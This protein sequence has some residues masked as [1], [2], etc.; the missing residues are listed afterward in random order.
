LKAEEIAARTVTLKLKT[1]AFRLRTRAATLAA[2]TVL[3]ESI[4]A[5]GSR[6]LEREA[7]GTR[8]RLIG[9][10]VKNYAPTADAD[11]ADL[12]DPDGARRKRVE[13]AMDAL[14]TRFGRKAIVKGRS[15]GTAS[16]PGGKR[17]TKEQP[18]RP[19]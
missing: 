11:P 8:Y 6:L 3:A 16:S 2:P 15:L 1:S 4:Y 18:P 9:I 12:A 7:D 13:L 19:K 10:G 5:A 17:P 14:R